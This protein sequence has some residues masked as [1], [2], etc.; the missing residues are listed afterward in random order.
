M[1]AV[2]VLHA[3]LGFGLLLARA[4]SWG[5]RMG[6]T[7]L[8]VGGIAP[9]VALVWWAA[10]MP[11]VLDGGVL[12]QTWV[13]VGEL[14]LSVDL[15]LDGFAALMVAIISGVGVLVY[16]YAWSYFDDETPGLGR[17]AGLLTLFSG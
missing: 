2:L 9:V 11:T 10:A 14:G 17:L 15:R 8:V 13:W 3:V 16:A 1:A 12:T 6:R 5:R 7:A 4:T